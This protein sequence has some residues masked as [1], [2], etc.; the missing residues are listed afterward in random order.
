VNWFE[1]TGIVDTKYQDVAFDAVA[2]CFTPGDQE[3]RTRWERECRG[4]PITLFTPP[5]PEGF[6]EQGFSY[7]NSG[8]IL[9]V[10]PAPPCPSGCQGPFYTIAGYEG[11][12]CL[13]LVELGD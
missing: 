10:G 5:L 9:D 11:T 8:H 3:D 7:E 1:S 6:I 13:H 12:V 4:K 2:G